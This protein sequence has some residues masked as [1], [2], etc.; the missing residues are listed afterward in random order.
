MFENMIGIKIR[1]KDMNE[2]E[3]PPNILFYAK[4]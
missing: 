3:K 1:E 2:R 4:S